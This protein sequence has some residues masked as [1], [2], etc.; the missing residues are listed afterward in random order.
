MLTF[1]KTFLKDLR[2][3]PYYETVK[4]KPYTKTNTGKSV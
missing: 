3:P 2:P 1:T 4:N